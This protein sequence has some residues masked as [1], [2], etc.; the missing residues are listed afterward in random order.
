MS[1]KSND[2][3]R[4]CE[5]V[6]IN[7]LFDE[8][9]KFTNV[10]IIKDS[11]YE[12]AKRA[13]DLTSDEVIKN[14]NL[15]AQAAIKKLFEFEPNLFY[16]CSD[17][18][19]LS[20]QKDSNGEDGDVRDIVIL[21]NYPK[22]EIGISSKHNHFALKHSRLSPSIDFGNKWYGLDCSDEYWNEINP[23]FNFTN[24]C[25]KKNVNWNQMNNKED[26]VYVP[27]LNAFINEIK[28]SY[29]KDKNICKKF[30]EYLLG[31]YDFY[32]VIGI[33]DKKLTEIQAYNFHGQ[34][35]K[36]SLKSKPKLS[37][38]LIEMPDEIQYINFKTN[39]KNTVL[40]TMNN[41]W[42]FSFRI[43]NASTKVENS[44]KFDIQFVGVP[45]VLT[46][47]CPWKLNS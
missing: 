41:G 15:S 2:Q 9:S 12:A 25:K 38:P 17:N 36:E 10:V 3:G 42:S 46:I 7:K 21:R 39:S 13:Y 20:I 28:R 8:I 47:D 31:K 30:V 26:D 11:S 24:E 40:I 18:I 4:A 6:L 44:L 32:K 19:E 27:L 16:K 43:H 33:D 34:L 29:S 14:F 37:I 35:N 5:F 45:V 23:I 1:S 22:W